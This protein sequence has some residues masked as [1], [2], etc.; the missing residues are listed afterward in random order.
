MPVR[1]GNVFAVTCYV[2][3]PKRF[4]LRAN[5]GD[6]KFYTSID[7]DAA[8]ISGV[9]FSEGTHFDIKAS[10]RTLYLNIL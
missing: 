8:T 5:D 3:N 1:V 2:K 6:D 4:L 7:S 10:S 9:L